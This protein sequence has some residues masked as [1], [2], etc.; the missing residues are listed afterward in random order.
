MLGSNFLI[1]DQLLTALLAIAVSCPLLASLIISAEGSE[2][3]GVGT[4]LGAKHE[5]S[6]FARTS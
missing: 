6:S 1:A 2:K 3:L 4:A 5:C